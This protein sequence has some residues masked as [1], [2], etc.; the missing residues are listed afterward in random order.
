MPV[1]LSPEHPR[2]QLQRAGWTSLDGIWEFAFD[3]EAADVHPD[4]HSNVH[5]NGD[6]RTADSNA[7]ARWFS[8][9]L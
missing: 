2:P 5:H 4:E 1:T 8:A 6:S 7:D 9:G 3:R